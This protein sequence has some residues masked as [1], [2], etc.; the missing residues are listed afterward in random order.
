MQQHEE[1]SKPFFFGAAMK[2]LTAPQGVYS[3]GWGSHSCDESTH[4]PLLEG[5]HVELAVRA[6][7]FKPFLEPYCG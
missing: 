6:A 4:S 2:V 5:A 7:Q 1:E 3:W